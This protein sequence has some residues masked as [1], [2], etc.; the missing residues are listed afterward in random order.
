MSVKKEIVERVCDIL[1]KREWGQETVQALSDLDLNLSPFQINEVLK[2]Q[3]DTERAL[4]FFNWAKDQRGYKHDAHTYT[5]MLG[6]LGRARNFEALDCLFNEMLREGCKP[7]IVTYNRLIHSYGRANYLEASRNIFNHMH[8]V[9]CKPDRVTY[10]TLIDLH[11][12]AGCHDTAVGFYDMMQQA[13]YCPDTFTYSLMIHCFG[14]AGKLTAAYRL[15]CEMVDQGYPPSLVTYNTMIDHFAKAGKFDMAMKLYNDMKEAGYRPDQVTYSIMMEVLG[16]SGHVEEAELVLF[17]M[18]QAGWTADA[19]IYGLMVDLWGKSGNAEKAV[20]WFNKMIHSGVKANVP[21]CNSLLSAY[22]RLNSYNAAREVLQSMSKWGL[23]PS[24][25]TY[26]LLLSCCKGTEQQQQIDL[27]LSLK[28]RIEHPAHTFLCS[29]LT[30]EPSDTRSLIRH[31]FDCMQFEEQETK[32]GFADSLIDFLHDSGLKSAA[33]HVWDI[34]V[35][36]SLYP[37]AVTD[38]TPHHWSVNLH[39]MS[40]GT[41]LV[42][43][44]RT[45]VLFKERMVTSGVAPERVYIITGWG[46]RSRVAGAS[47]VKHAVESLLNSLGSPFHID[48]A[49]LGCFVSKGKPL[50]QWLTEP[51]V[52]QVLV[53]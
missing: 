38:K 46:R 29:F 35:E 36:K 12:K 7:S 2:Q 28:G 41:A 15:F 52:E 42:A 21:A 33:G 6:I 31:F 30:S 9:G 48:G 34:V 47:L 43:L 40:I 13:G 25:Q 24:L 49:N 51:Q 50:F 14:K 16:H 39:V 32:R 10:G 22:L 8:T 18:E 45:L 19:P 4:S 37:R 27:M 11:T 53:F 26:T 44:L 23:D 17:E 1:A 3:K 20:E 5:T